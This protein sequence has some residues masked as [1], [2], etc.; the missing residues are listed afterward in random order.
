MHL[1]SFP[2]SAWEC[3][4]DAPRP[5]R[6][7]RNF[8]FAKMQFP[9]SGRSHAERGNEI[10]C[11]TLI[12][13]MNIFLL[14][15]VSIR[16]RSWRKNIHLSVFFHRIITFPF[17]VNQNCRRYIQFISAAAQQPVTS[18]NPSEQGTVFS[19]ALHRIFRAGGIH[20]TLGLPDRRQMI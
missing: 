4:P 16:V 14:S 19:D 17:S 3:R 5:P 11:V 7:C 8:I 12:N 20:R 1:I 15:F 2:R 6:E 10:K 13:D 9:H 18:H